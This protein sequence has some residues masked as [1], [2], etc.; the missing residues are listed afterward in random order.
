[1]EIIAD[2]VQF[3]GGRDEGQ[4]GGGNGFTPQSDVPVNN[5][6]FQPVAAPAGAGPATTTSPSRPR[7]TRSGGPRGRRL[8]RVFHNGT[9][10]LAR[11][12]PCAPRAPRDSQDTEGFQ[13]GKAAQPADAPA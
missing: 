5:S 10:A 12:L 13:S 11:R 4:G 2:S 7:C 1:M 6:D 9:R 3:L 8:L